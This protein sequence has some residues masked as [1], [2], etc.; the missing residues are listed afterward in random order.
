MKNL[1]AV[2][3]FILQFGFVV[4]QNNLEKIPALCKQSYNTIENISE[5][6]VLLRNNRT[7]KVKIK[8]LT[9]VDQEDRQGVNKNTPI[10]KLVIDINTFRFEDYSYLYHQWSQAPLTNWKVLKAVDANENGRAELYGI[11]NIWPEQDYATNRI[12]ELGENGKFNYV[13]E[14]EEDTI[15][16]S[17]DIGDLDGDGLLDLVTQHREKAI[18]VYTQANDTS[19]II[20]KKS[21]MVFGIERISLMM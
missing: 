6:I 9:D 5:E 16:F 3:L 10:N 7:G 11:Y 2:I 14:F 12:Y 18:F 21:L 8:N 13:Y 1:V 17:Y 4:A 15:N 20:I 19:H